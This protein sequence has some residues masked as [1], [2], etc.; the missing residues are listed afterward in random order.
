MTTLLLV[1]HAT[2]AATGRR[3][4][5]RTQTSLDDG[6]RAQAEAAADRLAEVPLKAVYASP[7]ARTS[8]TATIVAARHR[9]AVVP[10]DGLLEVEYGRWTDRPIKPLYK[11]KLWPVIQLRPSLVRFPGGE[12]IRQAQA[13]AVDAVE[14]LV[15][16]HPRDAIAAVTHADVIKLVVAFY[17]GQPLDLFQRLV[18]SPASITVLSLGTGAQP[19][20]TRFNDDGPLTRDRFAKP[21]AGRKPAG[22]VKARASG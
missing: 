21:R 13:R 1:R 5:G 6:G 14:D 11:T 7:L 19:V 16:R 3:L 22:T 18:I 12:T 9:V 10:I 20:L 17:L 4:G 8:E 2:T 15:A